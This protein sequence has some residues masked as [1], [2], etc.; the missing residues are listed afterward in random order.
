MAALE[1][2][3]QGEIRM[4]THRAVGARWQRLARRKPIYA[5]TTAVPET[6][7]IN[8]EPFDPTVS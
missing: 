4:T 8:M 7:T 3:E 5:T 2:G 1:E 6:V